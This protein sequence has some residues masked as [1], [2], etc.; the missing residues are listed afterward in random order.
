MGVGAGAGLTTFGKDLFKIA[1]IAENDKRRAED[2]LFRKEKF[3]FQKSEAKKRE[4]ERTRIGEASIREDVEESE[5]NIGGNIL[6]L[7]GVGQKPKQSLV[8][9]GQ[10][11]QG[12]VE[13]TPQQRLAELD[14]ERR[15]LQ[16]S[17]IKSRTAGSGGIDFNNIVGEEGNLNLNNVAN[18][19][20]IA[21]IKGIIP[22]SKVG[23]GGSKAKVTYEVRLL[24]K[25][26]KEYIKNNPLDPKNRAVKQ[27]FKDLYG[28]SI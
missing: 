14:L 24:I 16:N 26:A 6:S 11:R 13:T 12:A 1:G 22:K 15:R 20:N 3:E 18:L 21:G 17:L 10:A 9:A 25:S 27:K 19:P 28:V 5:E 4:A 8:Q 23:K 2:V 7:I